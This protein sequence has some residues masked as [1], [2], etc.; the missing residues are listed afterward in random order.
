M[1]G[2]AYYQMVD[3]GWVWYP[4]Y[5]AAPSLRVIPAVKCRNWVSAHGRGIYDV[6]SRRE[7]FSYLNAPVTEV[8]VGI[9]MWALTDSSLR[10]ASFKL[11]GD[12]ISRPHFVAI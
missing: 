1:K 10:F 11:R 9:G 2:A 8:S 12:R 5:P 3:G 7:D 4:P 6:V